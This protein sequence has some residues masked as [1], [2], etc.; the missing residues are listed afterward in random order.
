M[1]RLKSKCLDTSINTKHNIEFFLITSNFIK[2]VL[3]VGWLILE[4]DRVQN[5]MH[6]NTLKDMFGRF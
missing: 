4:E 2:N 1:E 6:R 3:R 5:D